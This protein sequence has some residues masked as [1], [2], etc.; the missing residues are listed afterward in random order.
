MVRRS[1]QNL[2]KVI[3]WEDHVPEIRKTLKILIQAIG[4]DRCSAFVSSI[5]VHL[6][7]FAKE[8]NNVRRSARRTRELPLVA[9]RTTAAMKSG[10]WYFFLEQASRAIFQRLIARSPTVCNGSTWPNFY[11]R[12]ESHSTRFTL[13]SIGVL[14]TFIGSTTLRRGILQPQL[15]FRDPDR[16]EREKER[17]SKEQRAHRDSNTVWASSRTLTRLYEIYM[18]ANVP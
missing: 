5:F 11:P 17:E 16:R 12:S 7:N 8:S 18:M 10:P 1:R 2:A 4:N 14:S 13:L 9:G 6:A 3:S 15:S